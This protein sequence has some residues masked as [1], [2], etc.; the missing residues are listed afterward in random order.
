MIT[1]VHVTSLPNLLVFFLQVG[2]AKVDQRDALRL[3]NALVAAMHGISGAVCSSQRHVRHPWCGDVRQAR[4]NLGKGH[5]SF[6]HTRAVVI[7]GLG[8]LALRDAGGAR[9]ARSSVGVGA[10]RGACRV[11][12]ENANNA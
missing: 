6:Q 1:H 8:P 2:S 9:F 10:E 11:R 5:M 12:L 4:A 3:T 7:F